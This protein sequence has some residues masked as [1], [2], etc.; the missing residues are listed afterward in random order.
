MPSRS[1]DEMH[2]HGSVEVPADHP[3]PTV[4]LV[5]HPDARKGW[6][7]EMQVTNFQLAP[8]RVNQPDQSSGDVLEGHAHL[9]VDG[10][11]LTRLYGSWYYLESLPPGTHQISVG[12]SSNSHATLMHNGQPIQAT[13]T[14]DVPAHTPAQ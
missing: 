6:N 14:L 12:L 9:Y 3:L 5:I 7:V 11:K 10:V 2:Q 13:V 1:I 8:E 4:S